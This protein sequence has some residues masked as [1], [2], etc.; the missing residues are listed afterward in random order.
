MSQI[1]KIFRIGLALII[2]GIILKQFFDNS[3]NSKP[4]INQVNILTPENQPVPLDINNP[5]IPAKWNSNIPETSAQPVTSQTS[6]VAIKVNM[7]ILNEAD[8]FKDF[9][10]GRKV[11]SFSNP[12]P[13]TRIGYEPSEEY[14]WYFFFRTK[15][16]SLNAYEAWKNIVP[17]IDLAGRTNEIVIPSKDEATALAL[18]NLMVINFSGEM[19][20]KE[21]I[22]KNLIQISVGKAKAHIIVQNKLREQLYTTMNKKVEKVQKPV[23]S[24]CSSY[25]DQKPSSNRQDHIIEK[26]A[27]AIDFTETGFSDTFQHFG[28]GSEGGQMDGISAFEDNDLVKF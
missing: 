17:N 15:I 19:P 11:W 23:E 7:P 3:S 4:Y 9:G 12:N 1:N 26:P 24:M 25:D 14:S 28:G 6:P 10:D 5:I 2:I 13:W 18:A 27:R 20:L 22:K 16:P 8:D 21:I